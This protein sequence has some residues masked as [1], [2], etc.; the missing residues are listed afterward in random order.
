MC[1]SGAQ[2]ARARAALPSCASVSPRTAAGDALL[3]VTA[4]A[5]RKMA[6]KVSLSASSAMKVD[7]AVSEEF[8][9]ITS[10]SNPLVK[11]C[12]K[13]RQSSSFRKSEGSV[14]V[15]GGLPLR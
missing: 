2:G 6:F 3:R 13:L 12:V 10:L 1:V 4:K 9:V 8:E 15:V 11:R 14:I 7:S 5:G